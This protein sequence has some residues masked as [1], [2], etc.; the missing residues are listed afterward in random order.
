MF[1][2]FRDFVLGHRDE[3]ERLIATR[4]VQTNVIQRTV[5]LLPA[6]AEVLNRYG[7]APLSLVQVGSSAGLNLNWDR[8]SYEYRRG[9]VPELAWGA[10]S[11]VTV[12][13][14]LRGGMVPALLKARVEVASRVGIDINLIDIKDEDAVRWLRALIWPD[15]VARRERLSAAIEVARRYPVDV[16]KGDAVELLPE[17]LET[18]PDGSHIVAF[19]TIVRYQFTREARADLFDAMAEHSLRRPVTFISGDSKG[20]AHSFL[21]LMRFEDGRQ[22]AEVLGHCNPH[23]HWLDWFSAPPA[24]R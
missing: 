9:G 15:H 6:F 23:G 11:S 22:T 7:E 21:T 1:P 20:G 14:E 13:C 16:Q 17:L 24:R 10:E 2:H 18:A 12:D 3:V 4:R 5:C 8:F 19:A